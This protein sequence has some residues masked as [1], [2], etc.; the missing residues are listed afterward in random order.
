MS[1]PIHFLYI[2]G[3][4]ITQIKIFEKTIFLGKGEAQVLENNSMNFMTLLP[5]PHPKYLNLGISST[6]VFQK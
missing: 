1:K 2:F 3:T 6:L 5:N 4:P